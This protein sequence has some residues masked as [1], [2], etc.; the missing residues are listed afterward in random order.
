MRWPGA[1]LLAAGVALP[2]LGHPGIGCP[3]RAMTGIPCPLCGMST[4]VE[5]SVRLQL[6]DAV[7]ANPVGVLVV[8]VAVVAVLARRDVTLRFPLYLVYVGLSLMWMFQ[9]ARF[10]IV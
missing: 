4:S 2:M 8:A 3:L 9:L 10:G 5:D 6:V 7:K 1:A